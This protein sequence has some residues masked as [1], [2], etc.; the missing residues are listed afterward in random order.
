[1][2]RQGK[3]LWSILLCKHQLLMS[4]RKTVF[5]RGVTSVVAALVEDLAGIR[6]LHTPGG[7]SPGPSPWPA[8]LFHAK[9]T[10]S[11]KVLLIQVLL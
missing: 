1:M 10:L 6:G 3:H 7:P 5:V 4:K 9:G 11:G 2:K 8:A